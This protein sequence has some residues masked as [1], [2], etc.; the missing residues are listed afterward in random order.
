MSYFPSEIWNTRLQLL[1]LGFT[2]FFV[3]IGEFFKDRWVSSLLAT[4]G[5]LLILLMVS[6]ILHSVNLVKSRPTF[7]LAFASILV[8]GQ[9]SLKVYD[10]KLAFVFCLILALSLGVLAWVENERLSRLIRVKIFTV[11][12]LVVYLSFSQLIITILIKHFISIGLLSSKVYLIAPHALGMNI[13]FLIGSLFALKLTGIDNAGASRAYNMFTFSFY[14]LLGAWA[15][16]EFNDRRLYGVQSETLGVVLYV[17]SY[18]LLVTSMTILTTKKYVVDKLSIIKGVS[19]YVEFLVLIPIV[20]SIVL[21]ATTY[22]YYFLGGMKEYPIFNGLL[23][24]WIVNFFLI[25]VVL[26]GSK[27]VSALSCWSLNQQLKHNNAIKLT[28]AT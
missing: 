20:M 19:P 11:L 25:L 3:L 24:E 10:D 2:V 16:F 26:L 22:V 12:V 28:D 27:T 15:S 18:L 6:Q 9:E 23:A 14:Y 8:L 4:F 7:L 13:G 21:S 1:W 5:A 17:S